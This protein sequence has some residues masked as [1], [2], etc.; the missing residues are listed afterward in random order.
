MSDFGLA[1]Q[2]EDLLDTLLDAAVMEGALAAGRDPS[3][4]ARQFGAARVAGA[5]AA[6]SGTGSANRWSPEDDALLAA[7][8]GHLGAAEIAA[9]LGRT[10]MGINS[11]QYL[12]GLPTPRKH[13]EY[14]SGQGMADAL[15]L[16]SHAILRLIE[17]GLLP[18]ERMPVPEMV[19]WR[20]RRT[21]FY[22]WATRPDNWVY[23]LRSVRNPE[24][25]TDERLRRLIARRAETWVAEDGR[26]DE[27]WSIGEVA[28]HHGADHELINKYI[29]G[30]R[31]PAVKWGNWWVK[32]S[33]ATRLRVFRWADGQLP[34]RGTAR[35][36]A[37]IVLAT[38]VGLP[39]AH[40]ARMTGGRL[41]ESGIVTRHEAIRA[42]GLIPWIVRTNRL[43]VE[44]R[45][46]ATWADW[47]ARADRFP[48][49]ARAWARLEAGMKLSRYERAILAGVCRAY[50]R[51][52]RPE[53]PLLRRVSKG[54][55]AAG[56]LGAI[57]AIY[58]ERS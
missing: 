46:G 41:S 49:L 27:W 47:R 23:I 3:L 39:P 24:R 45:D 52:H 26:P 2:S 42:H 31:L 50:L 8:S 18:A 7:W 1:D 28:R 56:T 11:R 10:A 33:D 58:G 57:A 38:A 25:I 4:A 53:H 20:M 5:T 19:V 37:F 22:A 15:G 30:G 43:P 48:A 34:H 51:Y 40:V 17:R 16:D 6:G 54:D 14:V 35:M 32:R 21:A 29:R 13:P 36:D 44:F 12:R 55:A 9:R